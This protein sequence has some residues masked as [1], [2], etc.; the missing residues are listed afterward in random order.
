MERFDVV[1]VGA[2]CAGSPLATML[3]RRGLSVCLIDRARFPSETLSTHVIQPCGVAVLERLGALDG[4]LAAGAAPLTRFSFSGDEVRMEGRLDDGLFDHPAISLRRATL[5]RLLAEGAAAAG[6][7]VRTGTRVTGLLCAGDRVVGVEAGRERLM[8]R[9]V[10]GADGR[11]SAVA[12]L[13]G[14]REYR[15][16]PPGRVFAW[17]YFE[18]AE[19]DGH[20]RLASL[21]ELT[22]VAGPTDSGLYLA[23]ACPPMAA[24]DSFLADREGGYA[25]ALRAWP[26]LAGLLAG[27]RRRGPIR[28]MASWHGYFREATGPGWVLHGDA[29]NFKD[30]SPA[31]G[32]ADALRQ[33]EELAEAIACGLGGE[34]DAA[35][36]RWWRWRDEDG[37]EMHWFA[38]DMGSVRRARPLADQVLRDIAAEGEDT[39]K[40]MRMLNHEI[41]PSR[42]FTP[43]RLTRAAGRVARRRPRQVPGMAIE[44]VRELRKEVHRSTQRRPGDTTE[45]LLLALMLV[46]LV[47]PDLCVALFLADEG[48]AIGGYFSLW[49]ASVPSTQLVLDLLIAS[50]ALF[51][52]AAA[53]ARRTEI[54][55]WWLCV[56]ATLGVGLCFGLPLFLWMRERALWKHAPRRA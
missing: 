14:A 37:R 20:L 22:Y 34:L 30:P 16:A 26:E 50:L 54:A 7:K 5:D 40:F 31:Q 53:E 13:V 48:L 41:R 17:A 21:G 44:G 52:W 38:A 10:I 51:V 1:V 33:G 45:R 12:E 9:L 27:A 18:G 35:L 24:R 46:G 19:P 42:L 55:G 2:R 29:G 32:M 28:V 23:A 6:A 39:R 43:R 36:R 47:V 3:A 4:I 25:A 8:A 49:F 56:P 11:K 15:Q